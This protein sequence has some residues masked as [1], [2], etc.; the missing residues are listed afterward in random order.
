MLPDVEIL[1]IVTEILK[2]IDVG[3]FEIKV[4]HRKL[5][6]AI[7]ELIEAPKEKFRTICS[8][9]DKLDKE[10]WESVKKELAEV[11]GIQSGV[12]DKL[13]EFVKLKGE[14]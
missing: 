7:V 12:A 10:S 5:L 2:E 13:G 3:K 9:V 4:S 14:P 8:S 1:K 11:K 6:D